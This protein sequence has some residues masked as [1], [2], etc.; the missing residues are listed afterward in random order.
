MPFYIPPSPNIQFC[1]YNFM[2]NPFSYTQFSQISD[3][4]LRTFDMIHPYGHYTNQ[5]ASFDKIRNDMLDASLNAYAY[6]LM[7]G[8][9]VRASC[10][11]AF[12][13]IE[14]Q[15]DNREVTFYSDNVPF[16]FQHYEKPKTD[17]FDLDRLIFPEDPIR[18][19]V[20]KKVSEI[21]AKYAW[22]DKIYA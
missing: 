3:H 4:V 5:A 17:I 18:D 7:S 19:W 14:T 16:T 1:M 8:N 22:A 9:D 10:C 15:I 12:N 20:E 2:M 21:N 13:T 11:N 6:G